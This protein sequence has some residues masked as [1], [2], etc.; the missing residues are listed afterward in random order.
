MEKYYIAVPHNLGEKQK[1][2]YGGIFKIYIL[3]MMVALVHIKPNS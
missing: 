1:I 3:K 2:G